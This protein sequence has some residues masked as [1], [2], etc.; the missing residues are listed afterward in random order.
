LASPFIRNLLRNA[1]MGRVLIGLVVMLIE[2]NERRI[3]DLA[4]GSLVIRER[5]AEEVPA[6]IHLNT[7]PLPDGALDVGRLTPREYEM[8]LSFLSRRERL[9]PDQRAI[10][11]RRLDNYFRERLQES[12]DGDGPEHFLEHVDQAYQIKADVS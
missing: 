2:R 1:D 12:A 11:A 6:L 10:L 5:L 9:S 7:A 8:L 3:G 4:A